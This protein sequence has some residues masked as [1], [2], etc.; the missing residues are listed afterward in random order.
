MI[1]STLYL[2]YTNKNDSWL[3]GIISVVLWRQLETLERRKDTIFY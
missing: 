2:S 3:Q 1:F